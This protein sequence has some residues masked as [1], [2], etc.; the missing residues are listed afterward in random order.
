M[1]DT[2]RQDAAAEVVR[3]DTPNSLSYARLGY[4]Q[5]DFFVRA[6]WNRQNNEVDFTPVPVLAG[7]LAVGDR[8]GDA[9]GVPFDNNTYDVISQYTHQFG[10][11]HQVIGGLNYRQ[12][13]LRST[14]TVSS[15]N[16]EERVGVY[17]QDEW[18]PFSRAWAT[19]GVRMDLH[20]E[21]NPTYSPRLALFYTPGS[22]HMFRISG[23][24][25][26][27]SPTLI[28]THQAAVTTVSV[29]GFMTVSTLRGS[30]NLKPEKIVSYE[31]EYRGWFFNHRI[32][33]R[34]A[35]F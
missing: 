24:V 30:N 20:S 2:N 12:S 34:L 13:T 6:F 27:R 31:G 33:P 15:F 17:L 10:S 8:S 9:S 19:A 22:D 4:E 11:S 23:S 1:T 5:D 29:F 7:I 32:R 3:F 25:G 14:Q 26:Y 18:R 16:R 28:E 21:I 35:L